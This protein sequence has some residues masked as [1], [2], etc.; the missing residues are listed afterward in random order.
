MGG[1]V[2][3][4]A[5]GMADT[6]NIKPILTSQNGKLDLLEKVRTQKKAI[7]RVMNLVKTRL[8]GKKMARVAVIHVNAPEEAQKLRNNFV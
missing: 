4:L 6:L 1:R 7:Q 8:N 2:G 5:A 3:K